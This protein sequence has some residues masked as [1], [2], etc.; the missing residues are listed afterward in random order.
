MVSSFFLK[1]SPLVRLVIKEKSML[2][3]FKEGESIIA[4]RYL[5]SKP[6]VGDVVIFSHTTPPFLF[7]KRIVKINK[8]K[9]WVE[10]DNKK[11]SIDSRKFGHVEVKNVIGK[12][13]FK[14]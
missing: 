11:V 4:L 12:V 9:I 14:I 7:L 2:P 3:T 6:K 1:Y 10:G 13:L 8:N 5:F